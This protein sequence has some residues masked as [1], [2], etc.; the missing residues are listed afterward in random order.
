MNVAGGQLVLVRHAG[1]E[2]NAAGR[3]SGRTDVSLTPTGYEQARQQGAALADQLF[4][5]VYVSDLRRTTQTL[6]AM[7]ERMRAM[8]ALAI[9]T[10]SALTERD[11]GVLE[12]LDKEHIRTTIGNDAYRQIHRG[13]D[14]PIEHG[15]SLAQVAVRVMPVINGEIKELIQ[16]GKRVLIVGHGNMLR[17]ITK[18]LQHLTPEDVET[19]EFAFGQIDSY[20]FVDGRWQLDETRRA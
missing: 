12:G 15:E 19:L 11:Y 9:R 13:W 1:S 7:L 18:E 5:V 14:A 8:P 16:G 10:R 2:W 3:L 4:D 20:S 17:A 6:T